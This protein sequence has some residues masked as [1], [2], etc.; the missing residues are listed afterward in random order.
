MM[1]DPIFFS[2]LLLFLLPINGE[3]PETQELC[4][5]IVSINEYDCEWTLIMWQ[6]G[7][8]ESMEYYKTMITDDPEKSSTPTG[9]NLVGF[10]VPNHYGDASKQ[11]HIYMPA[12]NK[13][14]I[15]GHTSVTSHEV[16]GHAFPY[17]NY[18]HGLQTGKDVGLNCPCNFHGGVR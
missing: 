5:L 17:V 6:D 1:I 15:Y 3:Q 11:V 4:I 8:R 16:Y 2:L 18:I 12:D 14:D 7:Q 10:Y 13:P 9:M